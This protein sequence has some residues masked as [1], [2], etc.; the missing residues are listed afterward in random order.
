VKHSYLLRAK[1]GETK[2][3]ADLAIE[4]K[5][6]P[7][8]MTGAYGESIS[9]HLTPST[10]ILCIAGG[11]G[12][13]YVLPV[14][15]DLAR[16]QPSPDRKVELIWAVRHTS[17]TEWISEELDL[18]QKVRNTLNLEIRIFATRDASSKTPSE[19]SIENCN[20]TVP[21]IEEKVKIESEGSCCGCDKP[22]SVERLGGSDELSR[23]P[24]LP[25]LV[26]SFLGE[27]VRGPTSV[28]ASGPGGM[29]SDLRD[30]V[31]SCND[32]SKVWKGQ[33]RFDVRLVCDDRLEW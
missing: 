1:G 31:A 17:N 15:L 18:L 13:T 9:T 22:T 2:K 8:I 24:D 14:L 4:A 7:V 3:V 6:T 27:T 28:F 11:T 21:K 30:I 12:I 33:E 10:N 26:N 29:I 32:G 5:S 25:L 20:L 16:Q 23:H 19:T